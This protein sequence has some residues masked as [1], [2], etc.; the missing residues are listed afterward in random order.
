MAASLQAAATLM[1][2]A[3]IGG[4]ASSVM[5]PSSARPS[6]HVARVTCSLQSDIREV[7]NKCADAAKMTGFALATSALLVSV[8]L[9]CSSLFPSTDVHV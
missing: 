4:R 5:L 9:L 8:S 7:A 2:P 1:Q 6:S 3:K